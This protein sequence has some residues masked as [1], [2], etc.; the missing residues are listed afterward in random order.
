MEQNFFLRWLFRFGI[1]SEM[2]IEQRKL[3]GALKVFVQ[4]L[5]ASFSAFYIY[6]AL[7]GLISG[8]THRGIYFLL[9]LVMTFLLY[10]ATLGSSD[11]PSGFDWLLAVLATVAIS[12]WI[13]QYD[14]LQER[15][16][17]DPRTLDVILGSVVIILSLEAARRVTGTVIP[18]LSLI[19]LIYAY[20]GSYLPGWLHH[21]GFSFS[22][23]V[24][25]TF[26][27]SEGM[28]GIIC[29]IFATYIF[30][31]IVFGAFLERSGLGQ[32]FI[33]LAFALTG[34]KTG[35]PGLTAVVSSGI[36][37]QISG[38]PVANVVTTGAFTIPL[39]KR[40]GYPAHFAAAVEAAASTGGA[41]MPPIMGAAAFL[42]AEFTQTPYLDIVKISIIPAILYF[43]SVGAIV[44]LEARKQGLRGVPREE[45]PSFRGVLRRSYQLLPIPLMIYLL[46]KGYSP[47]YAAVMGIFL[48]VALS[49]IRKDTRM[50]PRK[51]LEAVVAGARTSLTVGSL[52][53]VLGII[54]GVCL[55]TGLPNQF[56]GLLLEMSGGHLPVVILFIIFAGYVIGMGLPATPS[57]VILALFGVPALVKLGVPALTA[58]MIAFWVAVNSVVT[59]PVALAAYVCGRRAGQVRPLQGRFYGD[60]I[61][62]LA[63]PDALSIR[64]YPNPWGGANRSPPY[65][66]LRGDLHLGIFRLGGGSGGLLGFQTSLGAS[67]DAIFHSGHALGPRGVYGYGRSRPAGRDLCLAKKVDFPP[68]E[69]PFTFNGSHSSPGTQALRNRARGLKV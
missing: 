5:A 60:Q 67:D 38:S 12:Y 9:S 8:E 47:F 59:P 7:F 62:L 40:V 30:L 16:G 45:L 51:I 18:V 33:D 11:Q 14:S 2:L 6:T 20:L 1:M 42:I 29:N 69:T 64:L 43:G 66:S 48:T 27:T 19:F 24:E 41:Y 37:G 13:L 17:W 50:G 68:G 57:Y 56:A 31:F 21:D 23:I 39:M 28:L 61:S 49:W 36:F 25:Y 15:L 26:I 63:L 22:R 3:E 52:T 54:L 58:H 65:G 34:H 4:I 32:L 44:Y 35:G 46:M 55:L 10:K 53:G